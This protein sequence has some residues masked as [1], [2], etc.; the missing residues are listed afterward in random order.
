VSDQWKIC[1]FFASLLLLFDSVADIILFFYEVYLMNSPSV[2]DLME[3]DLEPTDPSLLLEDPI[4][5]G[6]EYDDDEDGYFDS[7]FDDPSPSG[8]KGPKPSDWADVSTSSYAPTITIDKARRELWKQ[9]KSE[10]Q[11]IMEKMT[12][13]WEN[14]AQ[15]IENPTVKKIP[16]DFIFKVLFGY[17]SSALGQYFGRKLKM[18]PHTYYRFLGTFWMSCQWGVPVKNLHSSKRFQSNS[19]METKE[20]NAI[21]TKLSKVGKDLNARAAWMDIEEIVN[22]TLADI[23][24]P[25]D[26]NS[27]NFLLVIDD[28]KMHYNKDSP[29]VDSMGLKDQRHTAD[30]RKGFTKHDTVMAAMDCPIRIA[31]QREKDTSQSCFERSMRELFGQRTGSGLPAMSNVTIASDRGYWIAGLVFSFLLKCGANIIGTVK[32][33]EWFPFTYDKKDSNDPDKPLNIAKKGSKNAFY[34]KLKLR[35]LPDFTNT[36][37]T[38]GEVNAVA[39]RSGTGTTVSLAMST[40]HRPHWWDFVTDNP[41]DTKWYFNET[42]SDFDRKAHGFELFRGKSESEHKREDMIAILRKVEPRTV[43]Q[44]GTEW[45]MD[46]MF[47]LTSSTVDAAF[48]AA[49]PGITTND[50]VRESFSKI[51]NYSGLTHLMNDDD[52][53]PPPNNNPIVGLEVGAP[54]DIEPPAAATAAAEASNF[55]DIQNNEQSL[56]PQDPPTVSEENGPPLQLNCTRTQNLSWRE[57]LMAR[58]PEV[59]EASARELATKASTLPELELK[60]ILASFSLKTAAATGT[61][62]KD[63]ERYCAMPPAR[64]PYYGKTIAELKILVRNRR[65][66]TIPANANKE[67]FLAALV[68]RDGNQPVLAQRVGVDG[69][70]GVE[71]ATPVAP[72]EAVDEDAD[73]KVLQAIIKATFL[74]KQVQPKRDETRK[75]HALEEVFLKQLWEGVN[76]CGDTAIPTL[77]NMRSIY[78]PGLVSKQGKPFVK[79][80]ADGVAVVVENVSSE[81][82]GD[83]SSTDGSQDNGR[84]TRVIPI[85]VKAR[86]TPNTIIRQQELLQSNINAEIYS[87]TDIHYQYVSARK[88]RKW[89]PTDHEALQLLHHVYCYGSSQA[90]FLVGNDKRLMCA[91]VVNFPT[92]LLQAWGDVIDHLYQGYLKWAFSSHRATNPLP[93]ARIERALGALPRGWNLD[94]DSFKSMYE[95][96]R[97]MNVEVDPHIKFPLPRCARLIPFQHSFWNCT[98]PG[99]DTLTKLLDFMEEKLGIRTPG[100]CASSRMILMLVL[101]QHRLVQMVGAK[102]DL[103][104]YVSLHH[105]RDAAR[106]RYTVADT[107]DYLVDYC[108]MFAEESK[109]KILKER[110][111]GSSVDS[112]NSQNTSTGCTSTSPQQPARRTRNSGQRPLSVDWLPPLAPMITPKRGKAKKVADGKLAPLELRAWELRNRQCP[113]LVPIAR[114]TP[115]DPNNLSAGFLDV[116]RNCEL[117]GTKSSMYCTGCKRFFCFDK[118]RSEKLVK[119]FGDADPREVSSAIYKLQQTKVNH[120]DKSLQ[121]HETLFGTRSCFHLA[122][123]QRF[124][125]LHSNNKDEPSHLLQVM[126]PE[127]AEQLRSYRKLVSLVTAENPNKED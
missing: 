93:E 112:F 23:F 35:H 118:D 1:C 70:V 40:I 73:D 76:A 80:S 72:M 57:R 115:K 54:S 116:R 97:K 111:S 41:K 32:R 29:N 52:G 25:D 74:R 49:A 53:T 81:D 122:H 107:L 77:H 16:S 46:R 10:L 50:P 126:D 6:D 84:R 65:I 19:V 124:N 105:Y 38:N 9:G 43:S 37:A 92:D 123:E 24:L 78:R 83:D 64:R 114:C 121:E 117:C 85:E 100:T 101:C 17:E 28:D 89:V 63:L 102:E 71:A 18:D 15:Y 3:V 75:G 33:S 42:L 67:R 4:C 94:I 8:R 61:L 56:D 108:D 86:V 88:F 62:R 36:T 13:R 104:T 59:S 26:M 22:N 27:F 90:I 125:E 48:R 87:A 120:R 69:A 127:A 21:W 79:D 45:F 96:W 82:S 44:G 119:R 103:D 2:I 58:D 5:I 110:L 99:S 14:S 55:V 109:A 31:W 98:K 39:Y 95:V 68:E 66:R 51:L 113:G 7:T 12:R 47:S 20:Y 11:M 34:K 91:L 60:S 30:N 106:K